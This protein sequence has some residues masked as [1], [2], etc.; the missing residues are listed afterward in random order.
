MRVRP[1]LKCIRNLLR[2]DDETGFTPRDFEHLNVLGR[3]N[4][5]KNDKTCLQSIV[6]EYKNNFSVTETPH[7][8]RD[9]VPSNT[10]TPYSKIIYLLSGH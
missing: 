8:G 4:D 5:R 1:I 7:F 2:A 6:G 9:V 10:N 3:W